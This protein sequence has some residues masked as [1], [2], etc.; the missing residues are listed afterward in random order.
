MT[1]QQ[2]NPAYGPITVQAVIKTAQA[3]GLVTASTAPDVS[4][5]VA[6]ALPGD[7]IEVTPLGTWDAGLVMGP[8]R[9]AVAGTVLTR[10]GN[11]TV[12]NI[13]PAAQDLKYTINHIQP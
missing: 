3:I 1:A 11:V 8:H 13:T 7:T 4:V 5:A 12:G 6:G 9:C 2:R 10:V